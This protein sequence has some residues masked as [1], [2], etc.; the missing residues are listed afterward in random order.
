[1]VS[2]RKHGDPETRRARGPRPRRLASLLSGLA[3]AVVLFPGCGGGGGE[4]EAGF[5]DG[6]LE[7]AGNLP[8][9]AD[10]DFWLSS[11][12]RFFRDGDSGRTLVGGLP[13]EDPWRQRYARSNPVDTDGGARP[14]NVFR[15]LRRVQRQNLR[16]SVRFRILRVNASPSPNRNASNGVFL[17]QRY[18]SQ[19][20]LYASGVRVDGQAVIKKK[21]G[22][23][24]FTLALAPVFTDGP[25]YDRSSTPNRIPTDRAV[26]LATETLD[27]PDGS[28][29]LRLSVD[30]DPRL[31]AVDRGQGS[32]GP[33][34]G[35]GLAGIRSD[36]FDLELSGYRVAD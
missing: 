28:V 32:T 36:F 24:T 27:Q 35:V 12:A 17:F 20:D 22:G 1:M 13:P 15:L 34:L 16:Q 26:T 2:N 11:G 14:Q 9:S 6:V 10:P 7:E 18:E 3:L 29:L 30:G 19:N 23:R 31:E 4:G 5:G 21:H 8:A 25:A 33:L